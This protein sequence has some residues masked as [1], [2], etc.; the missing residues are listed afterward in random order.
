MTEQELKIV[1]TLVSN[2]EKSVWASSQNLTWL[3]LTLDCK[4]NIIKVSENRMSSTKN[5]LRY[6]LSY[7]YTTARKLA[8]L[9][10]K[11]VSKKFVM[12]DVVNLKTRE[13]Y[14]LIENRWSWD[15]TIN[16]LNFSGVHQELLFWD[17]NLD[18][19]NC[20]CL[21]ESLHQLTVFS[22]ASKYALGAGVLDKNTANVSHRFFT[23]NE[24]WRELKAVHFS[25][26]SFS[27]ILENKRVVWHTD[28]Y[29]VSRILKAGSSK[30]DLQQMAVEIYN[31]CCEN[32]I[33]LKPAWL[34]RNLNSK[35]D[36]ISRFV[37]R[38]DWETSNRLLNFLNSL[39]GPLTV[40][41]FADS[42][43]HKVNR[44]NSKFYCLGSEGVNAFSQ[45]WTDE[46]NYLVP[47]TD[48]TVLVLK[49]ICNS[50][51]VGVLVVPL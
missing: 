22:D 39:W 46:N 45:P 50:E 25:I 41:R 20:R 29:A 11:L 30:E 48:E 32:K 14:K 33:V 18:R 6:L 12:R 5:Y 1:L 24:T 51:V 47:P 10:G 19:L 17:S 4:T 44:F 15:A 3:G 21:D 9:T 28:N 40:D 8:K 13:L 16:I 31:I 7:P 37:D 2:Y 43:N 49:R 27:Q 42:R 34:S 26:Q 23:V 36:T 38:D 35:A